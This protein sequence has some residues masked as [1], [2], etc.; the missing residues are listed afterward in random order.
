[1]SKKSKLTKADTFKKK[2]SDPGVIEM[3]KQAAAL[4]DQLNKIGV[5]ITDWWGG[6]EGYEVELSDLESGDR[7]WV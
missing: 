3:A 2:C 1:M 6:D 4:L 5:K 7:I